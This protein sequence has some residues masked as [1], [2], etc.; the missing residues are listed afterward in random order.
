M[1]NWLGYFALL[2]VRE[3]LSFTWIDTCLKGFIWVGHLLHIYIY[4]ACLSVFCFP[5]VSNKRQNDETNPAQFFCG[6]SH[7][8]SEGL[9]KL[10]KFVSKSFF[11]LFYIVKSWKPS[12]NNKE[13][14]EDSFRT[15]ITFTIVFQNIITMIFCS[16]ILCME[17]VKK[18]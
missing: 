5:F 18:I 15:G 10:Q 4:L 17:Y 12:E 8:S 3:G 6:T 14:I 7:D 13:M 9:R 11:L 2:T 1:L 16:S